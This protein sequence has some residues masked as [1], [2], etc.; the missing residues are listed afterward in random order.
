MPELTNR[1]LGN[2]TCDRIATCQDYEP[3][4]APAHGE[5]HRSRRESGLT[6]FYVLTRPLD[7]GK[8]KLSASNSHSGDAK[9]TT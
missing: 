5:F 1:E 9:S 4:C 2:N 7:P 6:H 3:V 8:I